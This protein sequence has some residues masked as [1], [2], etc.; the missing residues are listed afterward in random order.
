MLLKYYFSILVIVSS[1]ELHE[2]LKN[3]KEQAKSTH[4]YYL[5]GHV[6]SSTRSSSLPECVM[7]CS[8][9]LRCK[10]LNFR[11][12]DKSCDL[13]DADRYTHPEDYGRRDASVY[14]DTSEKHRK[15]SVIQT[16]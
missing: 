7:L 2:G 12:S 13:N 15:V 14:M 9:E 4:G 3:C 5:A 11:L 8:Y 16:F 10:S 1:A 6:I